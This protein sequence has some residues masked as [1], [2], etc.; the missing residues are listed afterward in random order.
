MCSG[1]KNLLWFA[2]P[3]KKE[4]EPDVLKFL[5]ELSI[6]LCELLQWT[7]SSEIIALKLKWSSSV[8]KLQ[9]YASLRPDVIY[10]SHAVQRELSSCFFFPLFFMLQIIFFR[11]LIDPESAQNV[12]MKSRRGEIERN[13]FF[14]FSSE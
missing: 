9:S 1:E 14:F 8:R 11:T 2:A 4:P 7:A 13:W 12:P 6:S 10:P 3:S 5:I